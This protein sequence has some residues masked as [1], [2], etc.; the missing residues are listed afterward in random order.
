MKKLF[1]VD[2][3]DA[4]NFDENGKEN[5]SWKGFSV[6]KIGDEANYCFDCRDKTNADKLCDFLN[7]ECIIDNDNCIDDFVIDNC[8]EYNHL[9]YELSQKEIA[10]FH[11]KE[12]YQ[13]ASDKIIEET[14]FK[15]LYGKNNQDIRKQH[16]KKELKNEYAEIKDLEFS[17]DF[18]KR[19]ITFL[20][21][22]VRAKTATIGVENE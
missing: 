1:R 21:Y 17:I 5:G 4:I 12:E 6:V 3:I 13:V 19:R 20:K 7:N 10:L 8:I 16:V 15:E 11:K 9:I 14:D 22:L 18:L 2:E